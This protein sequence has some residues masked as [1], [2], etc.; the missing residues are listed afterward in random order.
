MS[1]NQRRRIFARA[2]AVSAPRR[3]CAALAPR[4]RAPGL[5][6]AHARDGAE[7]L[8]RGR[9][10]DAHGGAVVGVDPPARRRSSGYRKRSGSFGSGSWSVPSGGRGKLRCLRGMPG[11]RG[12]VA[13]QRRAPRMRSARQRNHSSVISISVDSTIRMVADCRDGRA[14]VLADAGEHLPRQRRL[15]GA[16]EG[17]A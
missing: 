3:P 2:P 6:R 15:L 17:R 8:A 14:D 12:R 16:G 11:W 7:H 9:V 4:W 10:A 13:Q 5:G 1:S